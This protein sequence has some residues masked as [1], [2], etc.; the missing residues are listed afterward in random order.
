MLIILTEHYRKLET[1]L[2]ETPRPILANATV[3]FRDSVCTLQV[4]DG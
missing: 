3:A 4:G 1:P 2:T